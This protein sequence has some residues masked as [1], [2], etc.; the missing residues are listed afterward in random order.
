MFIEYIV[1][2]AVRNCG[3]CVYFFDLK[4]GAVRWEWTLSP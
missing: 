4:Y 3:A 1:I 2:F